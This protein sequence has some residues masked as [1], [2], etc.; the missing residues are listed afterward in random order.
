[1]NKVNRGEVILT[2]DTEPL[3]RIERSK[4]ERKDRQP[5]T[6]VDDDDEWC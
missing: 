6:A 2:D 1:M 5:M 4:I 3:V